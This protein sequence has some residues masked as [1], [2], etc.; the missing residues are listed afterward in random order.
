MR[1][2]GATMTTIRTGEVTIIL[3]FRDDLTQHNG[4][5]HAG[6]SSAIADSAGG[7]AA[8]T[9][10][11]PDSSVLTVE[12]KL[13]LMNPGQGDRLEAVGRVIKPGRNLTVCQL[14]VWGVTGNRRVHVA[15]GLQ[16]LM[17]MRPRG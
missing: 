3:P 13:N 7:Y 8:Y 5:F 9:L 14:D 2:M 12:F 15:T 4:Y 6:G 10:F 1:L 17:Q 16:T 11:D